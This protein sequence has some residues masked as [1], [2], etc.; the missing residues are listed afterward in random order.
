MFV[1]RI[2]V[3]QHYLFGFGILHIGKWFKIFE[4]ELLWRG[5]FYWVNMIM[6]D[7]GEG[8]NNETVYTFRRR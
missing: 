5:Y 1:V 7:E 2:N 3:L 4:E 8:I 6:K